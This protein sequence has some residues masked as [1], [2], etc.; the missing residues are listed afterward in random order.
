VWR[1]LFGTAVDIAIPLSAPWCLEQLGQ[2]VRPTPIVNQGSVDGYVDTLVGT[3][4]TTRYWPAGASGKFL[5]RTIVA[6][7][8]S[9]GLGSKLV[10]RSRSS[11]WLLCS[12]AVSFAAVVG[13]LTRA[14]LTLSSLSLLDVALAASILGSACL[15]TSLRAQFETLGLQLHELWLSDAICDQLPSGSGGLESLPTATLRVRDF[16]WV[17]MNVARAGT[18]CVAFGIPLLIFGLTPPIDVL[19]VIGMLASVAYMYWSFVS[20][21][22]HRLRRR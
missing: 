20:F 12:A 17:R 14:A 11:S 1:Y 18:A 2:L 8:I 16:S 5:R 22:W 6:E 21:M 10:G 9:D 7:V 13:L 15:V 3:R 19:S 4:V